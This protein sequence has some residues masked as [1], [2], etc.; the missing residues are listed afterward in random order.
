[1]KA[2]QSQMLMAAVVSVG[3]WCY[4]CGNRADHADHV[5]A[6]TEGG[7]HE[8]ANLVPACETCNCTKS[9]RRLSLEQERAALME[10]FIF[11][12]LV[13]EVAAHLYATWQTRAKREFKPMEFQTRTVN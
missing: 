12:P 13:E 5:V 4:Y 6:S 11:A 1:M 3:R 8:A 9:N 10:A 7:K 2:M